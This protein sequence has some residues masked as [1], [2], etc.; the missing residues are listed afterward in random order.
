MSD[1]AIDHFLPACLS[2]SADLDWVPSRR[3]GTSSKLLH[4]MDGDAGFVELL[5]LEPG[6]RMPLHR[7]TGAVHA[8]NL[9]GYR[10]LCTGERIGPGDYV[11]EPP[12]NTDWW[13][14][15]GD[16]AMVALV[17][18]FGSVEFLGPGGE[19]L[20]TVSAADMRAESAPQ[21]L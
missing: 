17:I 13:R 8:Y 21:A 19:V 3:P 2:R 4:V 10:E 16:E 18:V 14:A 12:G 20:R 1:R 6:T 9:S 7:H 11:Y 15:V 5:R